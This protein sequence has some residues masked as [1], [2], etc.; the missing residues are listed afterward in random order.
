MRKDSY[1][2][3]KELIEQ[4]KKELLNDKRALNMIEKRIEDRHT[5]KLA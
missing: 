4:N 1:K 5:I 2:S 3:L